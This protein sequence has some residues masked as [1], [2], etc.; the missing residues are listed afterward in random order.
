[1]AVQAILVYSII[2]P[3]AGGGFGLHAGAPLRI[4]GIDL[5]VL[6]GKQ[7]LGDILVASQ[8]RFG[9]HLTV[10]SDL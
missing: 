2:L 5:V 3:S 9:G 7:A 4:C 8:A 10:C 6:G 1:M